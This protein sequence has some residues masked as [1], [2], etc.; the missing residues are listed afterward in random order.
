MTRQKL[1]HLDMAEVYC[2]HQCCLSPF[3]LDVRMSFQRQEKVS[4]VQVVGRRDQ[5]QGADPLVR[6]CHVD[7]T[8]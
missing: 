7:Q 5:V 8:R 6:L 3:V 2:E 4:H 1:H